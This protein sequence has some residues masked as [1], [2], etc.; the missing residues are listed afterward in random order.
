MIM[1]MMVVVV[2]IMMMIGMTMTMVN[3]KHPEAAHA[4]SRFIKPSD[5][6]EHKAHDGL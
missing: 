3:T 1:M 5:H 6:G 4:S 2:V